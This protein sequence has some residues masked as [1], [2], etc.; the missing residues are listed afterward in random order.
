[1]AGSCAAG[2]RTGTRGLEEGFAQADSR[3]ALFE[4]DHSAVL[5][6]GVDAENLIH[7]L[8]LRCQRSDRTAGA[9]R[10]ERTEI[11]NFK[12]WLPCEY[13]CVQLIRRVEWN[14]L[15][16]ANATL[17]PPSGEC[18]AT[19]NRPQPKIG[20]AIRTRALVPVLSFAAIVI[21]ILTSCSGSSALD[22]ASSSYSDDSLCLIL[23]KQIGSQVL[24]GYVLWPQANTPGNPAQEC[25]VQ[26]HEVSSAYLRLTLSSGDQQMSQKIAIN[27]SLAAGTG[28]GCPKGASLPKVTLG[29]RVE[30]G[31]LCSKDTSEIANYTGRM[32][33]MTVDFW[34]TRP[35]K[36]GK[37]S[38]DEFQSWLDKLRSALT[39]KG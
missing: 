13:L 36:L 34:V 33:Q 18:Y 23:Q 10:L 22:R 2:Q 21:M 6:F 20:T 11:A 19:W 30:T 14:G 32:S 12:N 1:M 26:S 25:V 24:P 9:G 16:Q 27:E 37:I 3:R 31:L 7:V 35:S 4:N 39:A 38:S 29:G 28:T 15:R 17:R 5:C 8:L